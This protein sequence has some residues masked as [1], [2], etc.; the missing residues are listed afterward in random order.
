MVLSTSTKPDDPSMQEV[1]KYLSSIYGQPWTHE[2]KPFE[3]R[4]SLLKEIKTRVHL[5]PIGIAKEETRISFKIGNKQG[6]WC[7]TGF[8]PER[9]KEWP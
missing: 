2:K 1:I 3:Y 5:W 6:Y 8:D 9:S 7:A 4:W